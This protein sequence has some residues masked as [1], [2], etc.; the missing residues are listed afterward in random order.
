MRMKYPEQRDPIPRKLVRFVLSRKKKN[1]KI[2]TKRGTVAMMRE[3]FAAL[4]YWR[5]MV[6]KTK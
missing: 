5:P 4:V 1:A 3:A 6:S 2:M